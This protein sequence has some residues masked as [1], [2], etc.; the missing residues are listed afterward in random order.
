MKTGKSNFSLCKKYFFTTN[1]FLPQ[2]KIFQHLFAD[3][4]DK[5]QEFDYIARNT[6][7]QHTF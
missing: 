3:P 7:G 5:V 6:V 2:S 1:I 4:L